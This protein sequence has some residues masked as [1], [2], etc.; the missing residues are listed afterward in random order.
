MSIDPRAYSTEKLEAPHPLPAVSR[1]A[2]KRV[3]DALPIPTSCRYCGPNTPVFTGHHAEVYR[4]RSYGDWPYVYLCEICNAYVG[5][6]KG[7]D[8]PLGTLADEALRKS[9]KANKQ[10]FNFFLEVGGM[11]RSEAYKWLAGE[12]GIPDSECHWGLFEADQCEQ[13]AALCRQKTDQLVGEK[14]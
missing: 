6:H 3:K 9:R 2:L 1:R 14:S 13:A 5:I 4:G 11:K 8:L 12:M 10:R 7:T